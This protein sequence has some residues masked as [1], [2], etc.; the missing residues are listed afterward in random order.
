[1]TP[2]DKMKNRGAVEEL[3]DQYRDFLARQANEAKQAQQKESSGK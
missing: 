1:M 2:G 3:K